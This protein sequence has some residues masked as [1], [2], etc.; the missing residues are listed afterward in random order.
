MQRSYGTACT[1]VPRELSTA[2]HC[3]SEQRLGPEGQ[4]GND[5]RQSDC[6]KIM[7][8]RNYTAP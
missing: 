4:L 6:M 8:S 3:S 1:I 5:P 2:V 7:T